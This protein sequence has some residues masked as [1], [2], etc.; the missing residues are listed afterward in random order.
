MENNATVAL[1]FRTV[2][3]DLIVNENTTIQLRKGTFL[4]KSGEGISESIAEQLLASRFLFICIEGSSE[5]VRAIIFFDQE[6]DL[7]SEIQINNPTLR[8][9]SYDLPP[10]RITPI[11]TGSVRNAIYS[12]L[13]K[14]DQDLFSVRAQRF[15]KNPHILTSLFNHIMSIKSKDHLNFISQLRVI[16]D[17]LREYLKPKIKKINRDHHELWGSYYGSK[18]S[19]VDGGMSR[20]ISIP[21]SEPMGIRVGTYSVIPGETDLEQREDWNLNSHVIGDVL[22]DKDIID[23]EDYQTDTKRLQEAARFI[24]EPLEALNYLKES[25]QKPEILFLHGPLQ[26]KFETYDERDPSYIPG[27][28]KDFLEKYGILKSDVSSQIQHLPEDK[29]GR[30]IWNGCIAIYALIMKKIHDSSI[31]IV[32]VVERAHSISLINATLNMIVEERIIPESTKR[33]LIK[34]IR[35]YEI[36]DEFLFGCILEEG[37]YIQPIEITKNLKRKAHDRWQPVIEQ[38]PKV[39]STMLKSSANNFPFRVEMNNIS[40][41]S[42]YN[43]I[44]SLLYHTALLLPN[45]AFPVGIDIADKYAKIPDWL[46]KGISARLTAGI[47]N[48]VLQ[49]GNDRLLRQTRQLLARSPRD[50]FFRPKS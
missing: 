9:G 28:D 3:G 43:T 46:S 47:L 37:E 11:D 35:K 45:Y 31:P 12:F 44:M 13:S 49:T 22:C 48:K 26:N 40:S 42:S 32:G 19:F 30:V 38:F 29:N 2:D 33:K 36:K 23:E 16:S 27:V 10:A 24:L 25:G 50:F 7:F 6:E 5:N 14:K 34:V 15:L 4:L 18:I 21:G 17:R 41:E 8:L 20:I 39:Y 1:K